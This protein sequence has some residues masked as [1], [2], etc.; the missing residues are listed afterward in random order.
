V[1][2]S[3]DVRHVIKKCIVNIVNTLLNVLANIKVTQNAEALNGGCLRKN[4]S[5][6]YGK[7]R[8]ISAVLILKQ[9]ELIG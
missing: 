7:R 6:G 9:L 1:G 2:M 8:V 3:L 5:V 4:S